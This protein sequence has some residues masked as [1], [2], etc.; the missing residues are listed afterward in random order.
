[1]FSRLKMQ[2]KLALGFGVVLFLMLVMTAISFFEVA[3]VKSN[4]EDIVDDRYPKI[5]LSNEVIKRTLDNGRLVR[6]AILVRDRAAAEKAIEQIEANRKAN[7]V[8]LEKMEKLISTPKGREL[9]AALTAARSKVADNYE[10]MYAQIR[11][12]NHSE[13]TAFLLKEFAPANNAYIK[14]L[15]E[16]A[17]FQSGLMD[18]SRS[19]ALETFVEMRNVMVASVVIALLLGG[20]VAL[21]LSRSLAKQLEQSVRQSEKIAK[22]DFS[23]N[24]D[25]S[26]YSLRTEIGRLMHAQDAMRTGLIQVLEDVRSNA[27]QVND[28]ARELSSVSEQVAVSVQRQADSTSSASATLEELSVSIDQ[29]SDNAKDASARASQAGTLAQEGAA[30][31]HDSV[32]RINGVSESAQQTYQEMDQLKQDVV[33]IGNIVNVIRD[34]ADQTNLL[35]LNAA[36]E[37]A[38]AGEQGRGFAVVADEVRK[39]AERTTS[40]AQE[41]TGM[42]HSVQNGAERVVESMTKN[43]ESV[44]RVT[45]SAGRTNT[46]IQSV[47]LSAEDVLS[48]IANINMALGEQRIASQELAKTMETV[49]QMAEENSATAEE[50]STTS[51]VLTNLSGDLRQV[52]GRFHW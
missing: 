16:M 52:V 13:S 41:I 14:A 43:Q 10:R 2:E 31:V 37:A 9:F 28:S 24:G 27:N 22:G 25:V 3:R 32:Q 51:Q 45:E 26:Q 46:S 17:D 6:N 5:V 29:V 34:V 12:E 40:S 30:L 4:L 33:A 20:F 7:S 11:A 36:I 49:A 21:T 23:S 39:L 50:L 15:E 38:R 8:S 1:M 44:V 35:A 42:I 18:K 47:Q 19:A 48:S